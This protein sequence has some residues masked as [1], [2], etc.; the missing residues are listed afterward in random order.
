MGLYWSLGESKSHQVSRTFLGILAD[1]NKAVVWMISTCLISKSSSPCTSA[2]VTVTRAPITIGFFVTFM[3]HRFFRSLALLLLL[4]LL[5]LLILASF[6]HHLVVFTRM[7]MTAGSFQVFRT[8]LNILTNFENGLV[9]IVS[10]LPPISSSSFLSELLSIVPSAPTT[11]GI[12]VILVFLQLFS[13]LQDPN[14]NNTITYN[15]SCKACL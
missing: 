15:N 9:W 2:L 13:S 4:L 10:I 5:L 12:I 6:S 14:I 11:T 7:W 8:L 1:L 3:F